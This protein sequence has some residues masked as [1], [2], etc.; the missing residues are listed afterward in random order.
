MTKVYGANN[1]LCKT[2]TQYYDINIFIYNDTNN[3]GKYY[4]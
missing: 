3:L 2:L 4:A 1:R